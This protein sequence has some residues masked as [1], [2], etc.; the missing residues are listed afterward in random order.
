MGGDPKRLLSNVRFCDQNDLFW[1]IAGRR[2]SSTKPAQLWVYKAGRCSCSVKRQLL[3]PMRG[4]LRYR[5]PD[6]ELCFQFWYGPEGFER[7]EDCLF[8]CR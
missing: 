8:V 6:T 7:R 4:H 1:R 2:L 5:R 3:L